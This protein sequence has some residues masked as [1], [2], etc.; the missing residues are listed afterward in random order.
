MGTA[1]GTGRE[2]Y[3]RGDKEDQWKQRL[4]WDKRRAETSGTESS[5]SRQMEE[6]RKHTDETGAW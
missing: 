2:E 5:H 3:R 4:R 6:M 1:Q